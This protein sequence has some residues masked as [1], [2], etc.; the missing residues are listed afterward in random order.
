L[1]PVFV[2]QLRPDEAPPFRALRLEA[3]ASDPDAFRG[4]LADEAAKPLRWFQERLENDLVF[5]AFESGGDLVGMAGYTAGG[6]SRNEA[7]GRVWTVYVRNSMRGQRIGLALIEA[8]IAVA[9][10][11][12]DVLHLSVMADNQSARRLYENAGFRF[13]GITFEAS[14]TPDGRMRDEATYEL[15]FRARSPA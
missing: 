8:V 14:P 13:T 15:E 3:R 5:G 11:R 10:D 7:P 1:E 2:R 4:S 9:R 12:C 6:G